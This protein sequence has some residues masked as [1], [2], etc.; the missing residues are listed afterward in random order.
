MAIQNLLA[1]IRTG[2]HGAPIYIGLAFADGGLAAAYLLFGRRPLLLRAALALLLVGM[3]GVMGQIGDRNLTANPE[4]YLLWIGAM[5]LIS[6]LVALPLAGLR[7]R[8]WYIT[9]P[10]DPPQPATSVKQFSL[11]GLISLTTVVAMVMGLARL[12]DFPLDAIA[13]VCLIAVFIVVQT[14]TGL[15]CLHPR[16]PVWVTMGLVIASVLLGTFMFAAA[17]IGGNGP[18]SLFTATA[19]TAIYQTGVLSVI[20]LLGFR[21]RHT[22][23]AP[24]PKSPSQKTSTTQDIQP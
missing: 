4:D 9:H 16:I 1:W 18:Y 15:V 7:W 17:R 10:S 24:A 19:V 21:L 12:L 14:F 22:T 13:T 8:V 2:E 5:L 3:A 11:W 6:G 23:V 20:R